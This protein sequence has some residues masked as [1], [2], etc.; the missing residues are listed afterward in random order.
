MSCGIAWRESDDCTP[1]GNCGAKPQ[2]SSLFHTVVAL[3]DRTIHLAV[4]ICYSYV[5]ACIVHAVIDPIAI[6]LHTAALHLVLVAVVVEE[7]SQPESTHGKPGLF[8]TAM[9]GLF[10]AQMC[11]D[12]ARIVW[13][14]N[15]FLVS[16]SQLLVSKN[17]GGAKI[18]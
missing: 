14:P 13:C 3:T 4:T 5:P 16:R 18:F 7:R 9:P 12:Y 2:L 17:I 11:C 15:V 10:C 8:T 6:S 1:N